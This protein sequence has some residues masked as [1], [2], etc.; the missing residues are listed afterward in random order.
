MLASRFPL[1][2]LFHRYALGAA[3]NVIGSAKVPLSLAEDGQAPVIP[4]SPDSEKQA[5]R[6]VLQALAPAK[7]EVPDKLWEQLA[8]V[9]N[10]NADPERFSSTAGYLFS[11]QDGARAVADTVVGGLLN[12]LRLQ[13]MLVLSHEDPR[14]PSPSFVISALVTAG[15]GPSS[16]DLAGVI[17]TE[18]AERLMVLAANS[19]ATP[20]VQAAALAGVREVQRAI[21]TGVKNSVLQRLDREISL[22]LQ[23]PAQNTPKVKPAGAPPGPPV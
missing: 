3:I 2:Y 4:W 21:K 14:Q 13:R 22:F 16:G 5:I 6:L 19:E 8:P 1:V 17:Q 15:F 7:L 10:S 9:E 11:P 12:P 23:N 18:I 20:E